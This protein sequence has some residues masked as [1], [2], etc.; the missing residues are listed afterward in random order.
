MILT[1]STPRL[2]YEGLKSNRNSDMTINNID[3]LNLE[4]KV[5]KEWLLKQENNLMIR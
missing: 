3:L 4:D 5:K 2:F 1:L